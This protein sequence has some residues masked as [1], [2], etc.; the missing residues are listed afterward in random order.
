MM[1]EVLNIF[2]HIITVGVAA[3]RVTNR[4]LSCRLPHPGS[5]YLQ[6]PHYDC[7]LS[8]YC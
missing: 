8:S 7:T 5:L 6:Q 4:D 2:K 3:T 1:A